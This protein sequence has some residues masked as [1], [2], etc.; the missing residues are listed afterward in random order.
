MCCNAWEKLHDVSRGRRHAL[1]KRDAAAIETRQQY[2]SKNSDVKEHAR[3]FL[4]QFF[5]DESG[6]IEIM[7]MAEGVR[8]PPKKHL[9]TWMH[10]EK[11]YEYYQKWCEEDA[12]KSGKYKSPNLA[13]SY[14]THFSYLRSELILGSEKLLRFGQ[15]G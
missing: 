13:K 15:I 6:R 9:P 7:P 2:A 11:V 3:S 1:E 14:K 12:E 10:R 5:S 4:V 8:G